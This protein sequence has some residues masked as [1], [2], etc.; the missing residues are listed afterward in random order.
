MPINEDRPPSDPPRRR[1]DPFNLRG[2]LHGRRWPGE[3]ARGA[4]EVG[5]ALSASLVQGP[6]RDLRL[7]DAADA[8]HAGH[9]QQVQGVGD[10][11]R[12][13]KEG[14]EVA[15]QTPNPSPERT[16]DTWCPLLALQSL[17]LKWWW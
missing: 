12:S 16:K 10:K 2:F 3:P 11:R 1:L 8:Q 17:R 15:H 9:R 13:T 5:E 4:D 6:L 7:G 14:E